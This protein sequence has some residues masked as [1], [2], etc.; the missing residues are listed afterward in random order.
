MESQGWIRTSTQSWSHTD[1]GLYGLQAHLVRWYYKLSNCLKSL[2]DK[3]PLD[4]GGHF[5][6]PS[7]R[8]QGNS[9]FLGIHCL[10]VGRLR[11]SGV[12]L[13]FICIEFIIASNTCISQ[14]HSA[15]EVWYANNS[16][17]MQY[18]EQEE[19]E[20]GREEKRWSSVDRALATS[21][22]GV[23]LSA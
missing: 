14:R 10:I 19:G 22:L 21:E 16:W 5:P 13:E 1:P 8:C 6:S 9:Y 7:M 20:E 15:Y 11:D 23:T 3:L 17:K 12:S 4:W 18:T 2:E